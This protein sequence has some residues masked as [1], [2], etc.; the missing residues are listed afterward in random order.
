MSRHSSESA[1][2][3]SRA[4]GKQNTRQALMDAA[5]RI[6]D[7][8]SSFEGLSLRELTREVGL[9]PTAFYRHFQGMDALGLALVEDSVRLL[10]QVVRSARA[11]PAEPQDLIRRSVTTLVRHIREHRQQFRFLARE[12]NGGVAT[13]RQ[14]IRNEIRLFVSEV[15]TDLAR[16]PALNRWSTEDLQV[17]STLIVD[18]MVS[19]GERLL[20]ATAQHREA[21]QEVIRLAEKQLRMIVLAAA[22]W[23]STS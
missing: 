2:R 18:T 23:K 20:D 5:L 4:L 8:G 22:Q 21:E 10:R 14:A 12:R 1:S 3:P 9:V 15:A 7:E 19:T 13:V 16:Y 17:M 6:V 11:E